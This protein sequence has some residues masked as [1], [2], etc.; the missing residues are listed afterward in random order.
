MLERRRAA[1]RVMVARSAGL[2][3]A[4]HPRVGLVTTLASVHAVLPSHRY[5]QTDYRDD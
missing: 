3:Q 1:C 5:T 2:D 4:C